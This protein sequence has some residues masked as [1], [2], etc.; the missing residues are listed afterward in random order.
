MRNRFAVGI[1]LAASAATGGA[2][3]LQGGD[4]LEVIGAGAAGAL[5]ASAALRL[6]GIAVTTTTT[7]ATY[8]Q[9]PQ[10]SRM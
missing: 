10:S 7:P 1:P 3:A 8:K 4:P 9:R 6:A 2:A 5:G